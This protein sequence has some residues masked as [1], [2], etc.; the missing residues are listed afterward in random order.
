MVI[1]VLLLLL[2]VVGGLIY[3]FYFYKD[4]SS[5]GAEDGSELYNL[6]KQHDEELKNIGYSESE[7][8]EMRN[9][10]ASVKKCLFYPLEGT[11]CEVG[12]RYKDGCCKLKQED[13]DISEFVEDTVVEI[14]I[15][16]AVDFIL[17]QILIRAII[18]SGTKIAVQLGVVAATSATTVMEVASGRAGVALL[19][20]SMVSVAVD[21]IDP[22]GYNLFLKNGQIKN[23]SDVIEYY[24]EKM[25]VE[26]G[27]D[28]PMIYPIALVFP[29]VFQAASVS[30]IATVSG[31]IFEKLLETVEGQ[32]MLLRLLEGTQTEEDMELYTT[33]MVDVMN[34]K[35]V[36]RD[37]YI[38]DEMIK[39]LPREYISYISLNTNYSKTNT[40][41]ITLS[42]QGADWW[43]SKNY[44]NWM[45]D[46]KL[47]V[48]GGGESSLPE[49]YQPPLVA[50][51][52]DKYSVVDKT[53]PGS[54]T[55]P[56]M[57]TQT[58]PS[59]TCLALPIHNVM[60]HCER[61][62]STRTMQTTI[63]PLA[64]NVKF[65]PDTKMCDYT[66]AYC[67]EFGLKSDNK[68]KDGYSYKE[69]VEDPAVKWAA[70][71]PLGTTFTR[72]TQKLF[73]EGP[74]GGVQFAAFNCSDENN[75]IR[76]AFKNPDARCVYMTVKDKD[77]NPYME[78]NY[79]SRPPKA[80]DYENAAATGATTGAIAGGAGCLMSSVGAMFAPAC[81]VG[82][83]AIGA[84]AAALMVAFSGRKTKSQRTMLCMNGRAVFCVPEGGSVQVKGT[85]HMCGKKLS[86]GRISYNEIKNSE[87]FRDKKFIRAYHTP[88]A[89]YG[90]FKYD[91]IPVQ[92]RTSGTVQV[93]DKVDYFL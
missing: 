73:E 88:C 40:N 72:E 1:V 42:K 9:E 23:Q 62:K 41:G 15:S 13:M 10:I 30:Y 65:N 81:A 75:E 56:N 21:M 43:N 59:K 19:V 36:E 67:K 82:G 48:G 37:R 52:T 28:Y 6:Q 26:S 50:L 29:D 14:G 34:A 35:P 64:Y 39:L 57:I 55:N 79:K 70:E 31:D 2:G 45:Q 69:C 54:S 12:L 7:I 3:Y 22:S 4:K 11:T 32:N 18:W 68:N 38:Y 93:T 16:L 49:D 89:R 25:C 85:T 24:M 47:G 60:A 20:F 66:N 87:Q 5:D 51:Y 77:G 53:D 90:K 44:N 83:A 86:S 46:A 33:T 17:E 80:K 78:R 74:G 8:E 92:A 63:D 61:P 27:I 91:L 58:L 76:Q 71:V 84:G